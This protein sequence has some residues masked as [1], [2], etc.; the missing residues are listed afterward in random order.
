MVGSF[1]VQLNIIK[2]KMDAEEGKVEGEGGYDG[3]EV[4]RDRKG[5]KEE[6]PPSPSPASSQSSM[7]LGSPPL[8]TAAPAPTIPPFFSSYL[9]PSP[10]WSSL[11]KEDGKEL[12]ELV[13][14]IPSEVFP[15]LYHSFLFFSFFPFS[16]FP[17]SSLIFLLFPWKEII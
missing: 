4:I 7:S 5:K 17:S 9:S 3:R 13:H 14:S 8:I 1:I 6:I 2:F 15:F 11:S 10:S 12:I 16:P